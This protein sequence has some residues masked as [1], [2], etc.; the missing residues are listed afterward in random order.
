[1]ALLGNN[2]LVS[3]SRY[4]EPRPR[5][6]ANP[7]LGENEIHSWALIPPNYTLSRHVEVLVATGA[8]I[9]VV[10]ASESQDQVL[11]QGPFSH[12]AVSPNGKFVALYTSEGKVWVISSDFQDNL[13]EYD[14]GMGSD[15]PIDVQ[16]CGNSS[17][18]LVWE[19]EVHMVGPGGVA[20]RSV[21]FLWR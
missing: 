15:K 18:V 1:M 20:L 4:D 14:T 5:L 2:K 16:W 10:D 3:V 9:L 13:S 12:I 6:L 19:N 11:Q 8:T 21:G 17:V 7:Q